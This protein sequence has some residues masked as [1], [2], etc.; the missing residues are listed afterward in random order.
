[1]D[2]SHISPALKR[3]L[4]LAVSLAF[5]GCA[6]PGSA[7]DPQARANA[8]LAPQAAPVDADFPT[9]GSARW[10]QGAFP[11]LDALRRMGPGMGK[12]QVRGLLG[13]PHFGAG[14]GG[15]RAWNYLFHFRT[16]DGPGELSCQFM[17]RFNADMLTDGLFWKGERCADLLKP[18]AAS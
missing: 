11:S 18:M 16:G 7:I 1:M 6:A 4:A 8:A 10:K 12:D 5:A 2:H 14:L 17:V 3:V 15:D 13:W 9:P